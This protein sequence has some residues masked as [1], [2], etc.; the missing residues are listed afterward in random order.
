MIRRPR[1]NAEHR[2]GGPEGSRRTDGRAAQPGPAGPDIQAADSGDSLPPLEL[3]NDEADAVAHLERERDEAVAARQRALADFANYQR[4]ARENEARARQEGEV[5]LLRALLPVIDHFDLAIS[6]DPSKLSVEQLL[7]GVKI[8]R[9]EFDKVLESQGV[10][11]IEPK[12]GDEFDPRR[13][14]AMMRQP[15]PGVLPNHIVATLQPGF[16]IGEMVLRPAKVTVA[17]DE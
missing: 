7:G 3:T 17:P 2:S 8:V 5:S 1:E 13:H 10:V 4:R 14:E 15:A 12:P 6:Q 16:A 11:R 9:A